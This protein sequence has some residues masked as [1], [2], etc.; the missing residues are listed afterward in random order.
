MPVPA[1]LRLTEAHNLTIDEAGLEEI[2][3]TERR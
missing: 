2:N 1:D 3:Q